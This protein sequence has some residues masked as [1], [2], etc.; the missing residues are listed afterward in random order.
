MLNHH[1]IFYSTSHPELVFSVQSFISFCLRHVNF[2]IYIAS[3]ILG[4]MR[5]MKFNLLSFSHETKLLELV[6]STDW[7]SVISCS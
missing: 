1:W 6:S 7:F 2:Y 4:S 5:L 3:R